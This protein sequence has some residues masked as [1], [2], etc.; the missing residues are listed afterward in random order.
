MSITPIE[1]TASLRIGTV[2]Y[3]SPDEI[4]VCLDLEAPD[5]IAANAGIPRFFPRIN[6]YV[7]IAAE[8]GFIVGQIEWIAVERSP[9]PKRKGFQDYGLV[10]LP[11]PLRK[12][13]VNPLGVLKSKGK[14]YLFQRGVHTFPS[15]G[16][17]VLIPTDNQLKAIIE[18]GEKRRV[19]IGTSPL[20]AN[21]EVCIDPDRLFGRHLAVLGNTGS[22]KSCSVAGLI[23]W[24]LDALKDE[25]KKNG[26]NFPNAR[27]IILDPNGEYT[28]VFA[29]EGRVFQVVS[30][31]NPLQVPLWFCHSSEWCSFTQASTKA[32]VPLLKRALREIRSGGGN[33]EIA[34]PEFELRR[35]VSS[36]LISLR[37]QTRNGD[38]YEGWKFG[39]KLAAYKKDI[40]EFARLFSGYTTALGKISNTISVA[41]S[42]K[43]YKKGDGTTGYHDFPVTSIEPIQKEIENFLASIGGLIYQNDF[44][45]DIP[46][47]FKADQ[48]ADHIDNLAREETNPHFFEFLIMR[49]RTMLADTHIK[50]ILG[51]TVNIT[52]EQWLEYYIGK[53]STENDCVTVIDL[54]LVPAEII[55]IVTSVIARMTFEAL[56]RYRKINNDSL[57][58][59]LVMEEAHTFIKRYKEDAENQS[60]SSICCQIFEKIAREGRKFGLGLLL[61]SQRPSELSPTVLSQ[62]N[63]F[64]LHR[65][66]NDR[67]QELVHRLVPD[68]FHGLLKE[69]PTLPSQQA[70]LLGWA[71]ELPIIVQM[72]DLPKDKQ[73]QS[74]D[75]DFWS[76]WS[77]AKERTINWETITK[78]WQKNDNSGSSVEENINENKT[79]E[80][81]TV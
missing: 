59:V 66:S 10:D 3:V 70:I 78:N 38:N 77:G 5:G 54:S 65:I 36:I 47:P 25:L 22:G 72:N 64:L 17:P 68:N 30:S 42:D 79:L 73:P 24:S 41:L 75:P 7:L 32:Q 40:E 21:A 52:L 16:E 11:F 18:S 35:K 34:A 51:D 29:N 44:N 23:Q 45:E 26:K 31:D 62:C 28:K 80:K 63:S 6:S 56:Q 27:F 55:H 48:F 1:Y 58:T 43:E 71:S 14:D 61:S 12:M 13:K 2:E 37:S 9:F 20:A 53:N 81:N 60:V 4:K 69:L 57:P 46:L 76:V 50:N 33:G 74:S 19:K 39:W 49:I 67:D 8:A 15:V